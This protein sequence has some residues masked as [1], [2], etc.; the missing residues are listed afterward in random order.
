MVKFSYLTIS[1]RIYIVFRRLLQW[2]A[3]IENGLK[4]RPTT[5]YRT[6][7]YSTCVTDLDNESAKEGDFEVVYGRTCMTSSGEIF[8]GASGSMRLVSY[9]HLMVIGLGSNLC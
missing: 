5:G 7:T 3:R 4:L 9:I 6:H 8:T 2:I 1:V